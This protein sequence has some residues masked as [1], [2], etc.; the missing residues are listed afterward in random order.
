MRF[1]L[2]DRIVSVEPGEKI[3]AEKC[4]A[5]S[6]E[7]LQDHFPLFP[8]LPGVF[9][10]EAATQAAAWLI[11]LSEDFAHSMVLLTEVKNVKYANFVAPGQTLVVTV[12]VLQQDERY[13]TV[14]FNG[15]VENTLTVSGKLVLE[16]YNLADTDPKKS[17]TD[18]VVIRKLQE[19]SA[20]LR[21]NENTE[22]FVPTA[23]K[24]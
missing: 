2:I 7:Y 9:M 15:A 19:L 5:L 14:K 12:E 3:T 8:V 6:E 23:G 13:T 17:A 22:E 4:V 21:S 24:L 18:A 20:L 16:R 10:L 1:S 11:R